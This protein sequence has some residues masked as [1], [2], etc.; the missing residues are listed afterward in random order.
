M[1]I[2]NSKTCETCRH[3]SPL[4]NPQARI[5]GVKAFECR[6]MPPSTIMVQANGQTAM[7][8]LYPIVLDKT[9]ACA[10][11]SLPNKLIA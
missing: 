9:P 7:Q 11:H 4:D 8:T 2:V 1:K 10:Q 3:A 6:F 5:Q